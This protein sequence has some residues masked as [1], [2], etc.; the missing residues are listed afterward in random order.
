MRSL[1]ERKK[2]PP[3]TD[4]TEEKPSGCFP[5]LVTPFEKFQEDIWCFKI[6]DISRLKN[7]KWIQVI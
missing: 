5:V 3:Q 4:E 2:K 6:I 1:L 7:A